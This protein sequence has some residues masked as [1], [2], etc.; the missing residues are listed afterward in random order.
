ML[1][2]RLSDIARTAGNRPETARARLR[3]A[4]DNPGKKRLPKP[5]EHWTFK[6][7]DASRVLR[8]ISK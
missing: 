8:L 7:R 6:H 4:Y 3:K 2:I 5:L 1:A